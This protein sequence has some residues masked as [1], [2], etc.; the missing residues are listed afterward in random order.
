MDDR[1]QP[2]E[3][4]GIADDPSRQ[5]FAIDATVLAGAREG[6]LDRCDRFAV[7]ERVDN[8]IGVEHG[9]AF[10]GEKP[11]RCA[12]AHSDGAGESENQHGCDYAR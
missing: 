6:R 3:R 2:L 7:V 10:F 12:L 1:L 5:F 11:R 4:R 9:H 8:R